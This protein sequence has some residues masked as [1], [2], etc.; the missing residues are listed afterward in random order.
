MRDRHKKPQRALNP[1]AW[2]VAGA[3]A[4]LL[5]AV[6]VQL[7]AFSRKPEPAPTVDLSQLLPPANHGWSADDIPVADTETLKTKVREMLN[8]STAVQRAS[9]FG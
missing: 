7:G 4:V 2:S 8:Y 3:L 1:A 6:A 9:P 5:V